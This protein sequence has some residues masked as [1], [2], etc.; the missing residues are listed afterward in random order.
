MRVGID[1]RVVPGSYGGVEQ[2][3]IGLAHGLGGLA[4]EDDEYL[5]L[6]NPGHA[7][8]LDP[9][10]GANS[11]IVVAARDP[12][13]ASRL[14]SARSRLA[15]RYPV[16]RQVARRVPSARRGPVRLPTSDGMLETAGAQLIHFPMQSGFLTELPSIYQPWDLQHRHMPEF[17]SP[18]TIAWREAT[19]RAFCRQAS[20]VITAAEWHARDVAEAY[21]IPTERERVV[22][23]PPPMPAYPSLSD[24]DVADVRDTLG[25]P[26]DFLF[27]PAHTWPH[28]NHIGLVRAVA[29]ARDAH[30]LRI[31]VVCTGTMTTHYRAIAREIRRMRVASQFR[32]LGFV[33]PRELRAIYRSSRGLFFPSLFEGWGIPVA[34]AFHLGVAVACSRVTSLPELAGRAALLFD[35]HDGQA[36]TAALIRFWN[37]DALRKT[38]VERGR[39]VARD[40]NWETTSRAYREC[41]RLVLDDGMG[42]IDQI[43][44]PLGTVPE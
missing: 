29:A 23:V 38:L 13:P 3:V 9:Y 24:D 34:E 10:L 28:K 6:V 32:F 7:D 8:W 42:P 20:L 14:S 44:R 39:V 33:S 22:P 36:V 35:P 16:V 27:F 19:Y 41:Y 17:F 11:R 18:A 12:E 21:G 31:S 25:L 2:F 37:D 26:Q 15:G 43:S 4:D 1:A 5:F 40:L 30:G